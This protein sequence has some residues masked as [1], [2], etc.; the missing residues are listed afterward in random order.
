MVAGILT[1]CCMGTAV[2]DGPRLQRFF[3]SPGDFLLWVALAVLASMF[4]IPRSRGRSPLSMQ[5]GVDMAA[6]FVFGPGA[7]TWL[8]VF[9]RVVSNLGHGWRHPDSVVR[10]A[11]GVLPVAVTGWTYV[12]VG[13]P[14][15][16]DLIEMPGG[17]S[18]VL[19]AGLF[20]MML[21]LGLA[22][23]GDSLDTA[24]R[25]PRSLTEVIRS[26]ILVTGPVLAGGIVL[27]VLRLNMGPLTAIPF[28]LVMILAGHASSV[29]DRNR[30]GHRESVR[31]L[32]TAVDAAD[33]ITRGHSYR[34]AKMC[35]RVARRLGYSESEIEKLEYAA[36]LHDIG[37]TALQ[38]DL[39]AK[40]GKLTREEH[41]AV[42]THPRIGAD[43]L[44]R[45]GLDED[46]ERIVL[47]H[48]EQPDGKGYPFGLKGET[49]PP[50][51][52]IIMAVAAFDAMTSDRPYRRGL[53]PE[54]AFEEL[55]GCSGSQFFPDVVEALID[56]Y[57]RGELY[58]EFEDRELETYWDGRSSSRALDKYLQESDRAPDVP[59]KLGVNEN[60]DTDDSIPI[61]DFPGGSGEG[62]AV[63]EYRLDSAGRAVLGVAEQSD[64]GCVRENNEDR[65]AV[66]EGEDPEQ[67]IL[68]VVA[69]GM[70][71][72]VAGEVA[73][74][75]AVD[76]VGKAFFENRGRFGPGQA[77]EHAI[78]LANEAVY[79][80][81]N[82]DPELEGMGTTLT[83]VAVVGTEAV[84]GHVGDSRA[85]LVSDG[86][87]ALL[88][89]DHTLA[90]ELAAVGGTRMAIPAGAKNVLSRCLGGTREVE[91]DLSEEPVC[92]RDGDIF[93]LCSDGL[94]NV[95]EVEE[96]LRIAD[97]NGPDRACEILVELARERGAPDNITVQVA[98]L[99]LAAA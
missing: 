93:V 85:Y 18:M 42:R 24:K 92:L 46:A 23:L 52:R 67:G 55:L 73:S 10:L 35:T 40:P 98:R 80:R 3:G 17:I 26:D 8:C 74:G 1:A 15:G 33:P 13:G 58:E 78:A 34:I 4:F 28:V 56:L 31:T 44:N 7:A 96:I 37:R 83:A 90:A 66:Q 50:G 27:G 16:I 65:C 64:V 63:R 87:I 47:C 86:G 53:D 76:T 88:T 75:I 69:D 91:V 49:I 6:V 51:S 41:F 94:S 82:G 5:P 95:V 59:R 20:Y 19:T 71:G 22:V 38:H 68:L 70:G 62:S 25:A 97:G 48:H 99:R 54:A 89:Q 21:E 14:V 32:M 61:I 43:M 79:E 45:F 30:R 81:A 9:S 84:V 2:L 29:L 60:G 72:A 39:L 77:L 36:L 57:S 11:R 12:R